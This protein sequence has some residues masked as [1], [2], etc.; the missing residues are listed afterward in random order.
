MTRLR[1]TKARKRK[2]RIKTDKKVRKRLNSIKTLENKRK[3]HKQKREIFKIPNGEKLNWLRQK[4]IKLQSELAVV[5]RER[6][7]AQVTQLIKYIIRNKFTQYWAVYRTI[8][9]QGSRSK[10]ITDKVKLSTQKDYDS[11]RKQL[12][13]IIK[14]PENYKASPLKRIWIPKP[15][16]SEFRPI[17][18]PSYV[19]RALQHL[20]LIV[21]DVFQ[22]EFADKDSYGF[23]S[24]RSP[25][26]AAKA[27]TLAIWQRKS[28]K[29]PKFAIELDIRKCFDSISPKFIINEVANVNIAD[30]TYKIKN[31]IP[32]YD[33]ITEYIEVIP[34]VIIEKWLFSGY[35]DTAGTL[36][37][38]NMIIPTQAAI[39]QGGPISPTIANMVLNGIQKA[40]ENSTNTEYIDS[41]EFKQTIWIKPDD[42][43]SWKFE[44]K[45][46]L[47]STGLNSE[48]YNIVNKQL[49]ELGYDPPK[50]MA[51]NFLSYTWPHSRGL[52]S[53]KILNKNSMMEKRSKMVNNAWI[54]AFRFADDCLTLLNDE[55][56]IEKVLN[57]V[58]S[59]LDP[60]GLELN[61]K[62]VFIRKLHKGEKFQFVGYEFS[63]VK[64][65]KN[66][67]IYNYPPAAKIKNVKQKVKLLFNKYKLQPYT[68]YYTVNAVIRGW[69]TF[70]SNGNS[71]NTFNNL[72]HWLWK[73]TFEYWWKYYKYKKKYRIRSQRQM[74]KLLA[75]DIIKEH[76]M[77]IQN[78]P[79]LQK[80]G[81]IKEKLTTKWWIVPS[82]Y[83]LNDRWSDQ[84][85]E[86]FLEY[87]RGI[88][89]STPSII[90]GLSAY[91]PQERLLLEDKAIYW[92]GG[93]I[94]DL[95]I[96]SKGLCKLC[97]CSLL[98][99]KEADIEMHHIQPIK[100]G[101]KAKF[102]NLAAL[103]R[104]CHQLVTAA[105]RSE[106]LELIYTL[107]ASKI[108]KN[109]SNLIAPKQT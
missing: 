67:K 60:R 51:R 45:E 99:E 25:G 103:C 89:V 109:V 79:K 35:I 29:P 49:R 63:I 91:L 34:K 11:L 48:N 33:Q 54:R 38:K 106:N 96:K 102:T 21:L 61:L 78:Q 19:D 28:Y 77:L 70:Y 72:T 47:R 39:P 50:G 26:W 43:V 55:S 97:N 7:S 18:I 94:R 6:E 64:D 56:A 31:N 22:E 73:K 100:Y 20:Y 62:K 40:I 92:K 71:S 57:N 15:K 14:C 75:Y 107:E 83:Y 12:W 68:A 46:V 2:D 5:I 86:F 36:S 69:C 66:W 32:I 52:W 44:D 37:P 1:I 59:F 3:S 41:Q 81:S 10:G 65:H 95:L 58:K 17:S 23:R 53:Y 108:L 93:I 105:V 9:S 104:E 30:D 76:L 16:S 13:Q 87:P 84:E 98:N 42:I 27:V 101:G 80:D 82:R 74:K 85:S 4:I 88:K 90:T 24:Y 8:S